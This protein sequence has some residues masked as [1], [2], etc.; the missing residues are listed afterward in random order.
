M[1]G[2]RNRRIAEEAGCSEGWVSQCLLGRAKP[3]PRLRA[4]V[5]HVLQLPE[6]MLFHPEPPARK[7]AR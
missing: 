5:A 2:I 7:S 3:S 6:E 1:R 4:T